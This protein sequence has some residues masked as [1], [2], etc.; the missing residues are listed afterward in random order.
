MLDQTSCSVPEYYADIGYR[1]QN[2]IAW[3][4]Q[5]RTLVP[6]KKKGSLEALNLIWHETVWTKLK[7]ELDQPNS[8]LKLTRLMI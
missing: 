1:D 7:D 8:W 3:R 6:K 4:T 2:G 5:G